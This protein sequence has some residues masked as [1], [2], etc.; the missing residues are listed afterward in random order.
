MNKGFQQSFLDKFNSSNYNIERSVISE[1]GRILSTK[2][3]Y[4]ADISDYTVFRRP[5]GYGV[6]D[7]QSLGLSND[8]ISQFAEHCRQAILIFEPRVS[9]VI[10][11]NTEINSNKQHIELSLILR[12]KCQNL[13]LRYKVKLQ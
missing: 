9:D 1:I 13:T 7:L 2:L 5:Y 6:K 10:I 8:N 3:S 4:V 11:E 12:L